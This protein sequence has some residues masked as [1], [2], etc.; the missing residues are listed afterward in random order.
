MDPTNEANGAIAPKSSP[1]KFLLVNEAHAF[2]CEFATMKSETLLLPLKEIIWS[3]LRF[4][5]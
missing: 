2:L 3:N 4:N 5:G 1:M